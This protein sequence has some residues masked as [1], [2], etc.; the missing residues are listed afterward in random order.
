MR[1]AALRG[2]RGQADFSWSPDPPIV[3]REATFTAV[4]DPAIAAY[5]WDLDGNGRYDDAGMRAARGY[6]RTFQNVRTYEIGLLTVDVNGSVSERRRSVTV[7]RRDRP[8]PP[9]RGVL[10][11]LPGRAG[12]G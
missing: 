5:R 10:R 11:V 12:R 7:V 9:A 1:A 8:E 3:K 4:E 2:R 6:R